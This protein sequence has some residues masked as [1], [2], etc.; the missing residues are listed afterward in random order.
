M[1]RLRLRSFLG[2][3]TSK[4][5]K[6]ASFNS[7]WL[8]VPDDSWEL[9]EIDTTEI[10]KQKKTV[11]GISQKNKGKTLKESEMYKDV[12][13][14]LDLLCYYDKCDILWKGS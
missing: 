8:K 11:Q 9:P 3:T 4:V 1:L 13:S 5:R 12:I 14:L 2:L 10:Q 6:E 7:T